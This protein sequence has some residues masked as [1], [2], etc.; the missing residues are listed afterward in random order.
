M[1]STIVIRIDLFLSI[2]ISG[3]SPDCHAA[4][5][6]DLITVICIIHAAAPMPPH[7]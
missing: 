7:D 3:R 1:P 2:A 6:I 5:R 4:P